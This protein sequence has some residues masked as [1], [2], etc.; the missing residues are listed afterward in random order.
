MNYKSKSEEKLQGH[1]LTSCDVN[2]IKMK[3]QTF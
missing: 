2:N 1:D 3:A